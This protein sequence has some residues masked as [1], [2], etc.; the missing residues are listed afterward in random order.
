MS[1][2]KIPGVYIEEIS[3]IPPSIVSVE[4]AIPAFIGYTEKAQLKKTGD[5]L[6][7][8]KRIASL[9]EYEVLFG[10]PEPEN[11]I[12]ITID[13]SQSN[14]TVVNGKV[15]TPSSYL[16]YYSMQMFFRNGGGPCYII[17]V[18][19]YSGGGVI[20]HSHLN[21]GLNV[22]AKEDKV[23]LIVFPDGLNLSTAHDYYD[24]YKKAME[25]CAE[26]KD[27]FAVMDVWIDTDTRVDNIKTL[28]DFDFGSTVALK[29]G[30][31]YY[32]SLVTK[33]EHAYSDEAL[34]LIIG[35]GDVGLSG[36][37]KALKGK[38]DALYIVAKNEI[39]NIEM[40]LPAATAVLGKYVEVD[41]TRGVWKAPA[42]VEID[43]A[44]RPA[45]NITAN[46]EESLNMDMH[47]G[48]SINVIRSLPGRGTAII[49]GARTLA[50][51]D[52]EWRY[53]PIRRFNMMV[54]KSVK[55]A[56]QQF[57]FEPNERNTWV[58]VK[59]MIENYLTQLWKAG[60]LMG[61]KSKEA[62]FTRV[63]LGETMTAVD[64]FEGRLIVEIG[65]AVIR[66]AEF[67]IL[68]FTHNMTKK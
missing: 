17:S 2:Y 56:V 23:T 45:I 25:Q 10:G 7:K 68:K 64:I 20:I 32:P 3:T 1:K 37:L 5:L 60:A 38:N 54:E 9:Q 33:I 66:P 55:N 63:G 44:I 57:L 61:T 12:V 41:N 30:A 65:M 51:N 24:L 11:S 43:F 29:Y 28:R 36:T 58:R 34:V 49:W 50:G 35:K 53:V 14:K 42:N 26:L 18:G 8:P 40:L 39:R 46:A 27:R 19:N 21:D 15:Q 4:T 62:F 6:L 52:S 16:M 47:T 48:K 59:S 67:I 13:T 22:A 31:V